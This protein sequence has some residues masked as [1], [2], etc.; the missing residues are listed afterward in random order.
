MNW[1]EGLECSMRAGE[2][3]LAVL[4]DPDDLPPGKAWHDFLERLSA[5]PVTDVLIGGSLLIHREVQDIM[6]TLRQRIS[7]PLVLFPGEPEQVT[8]GADA[9]LF[10]SLISGR[11]PELL[12]GKH[13]NAALRIRRMKLEVIPT[14][15]ML[16]GDGPL[17]TAAYMSQT[18]PIPKNKPAIASATA[19]AG[20]LLGLRLMYLD[21][22][23]GAR[24][25]IPNNMIAAVREQVR[26]PIVVG[27]GLNDAPSIRAAWCSGADLVVVGT[28]IEKRPTDFSW[29]PDPKIKMSIQATPSSDVPPVD[30]RNSL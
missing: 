16:I 15:Y 5:S 27:G 1:L 26:C 25:P 29:L 9:L 28:A 22:G 10:L 8:S 14:G 24:D 6:S 13:V 3:R 21:A 7:K 18:L 4:I 17:T 20:E 30:T 2:K 23:S 12:V 19:A 11:N